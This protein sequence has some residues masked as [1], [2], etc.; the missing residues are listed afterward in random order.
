MTARKLSV[1]LVDQIVVSGANFIT[2]ILVGRSGGPHELANYALGFSAVIIVF[3]GVDMLVSAPYTVFANRLEGAARAAYRGAA[4]LQCGFLSVLA[5]GV[6]GVWG[7]AIS[8]G[9]G[10]Q[11]LAHTLYVLAAG[12]S[13]YVLREF[14]R[15]CSYAHLNAKAAMYVDLAAA[16]L[17]IT[18]IA[19]LSHQG[20]LSAV[21]AFATV[22]TANALAGV[23]WLILSRKG[24]ALQRGQII[25]AIRR[26]V[27]FG[28][29]ILMGKIAAHLNSDIFLL[30]L[31]T[32][33][34]GNTAAGIFAACMTV[35]HLANPFIMGTAQVLTPRLAQA[36]AESGIWE[37]K[38]V[39]RKATVFL[40]LALSGF[41]LGVFLFGGEALKIFYGSQYEGHDHILIP[42]AFS[43]LSF[44]LGIPAA[45]SL[46]VLERPEENLKANLVGIFF[47]AA[48]ASALVFRF[49]MMG[50][51]CGLLCGQISAAVT[52]WRIFSRV[53]AKT[54]FLQSH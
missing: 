29:W 53:A 2:T 35:I 50:L 3:S 14:A 34:L 4:L 41:C 32:F 11:G 45:C 12:I 6:L 36:W 48:V 38:R 18:C 8:S 26:N 22:G 21:T 23:S 19:I 54:P 5:A 51:V 31:M 20:H 25:P 44:V 1:S 17:Q 7:L 39:M 16:T 46:F 37:V 42:L 40:G 43:V 9:I 28:S 27:S 24:F 15:Q 52:R 10:P 30:W 47:T 13:F 49:E 33:A